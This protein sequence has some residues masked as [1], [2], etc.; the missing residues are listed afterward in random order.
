[1]A[2]YHREF[3]KHCIGGWIN[4]LHKHGRQLK[5]FAKQSIAPVLGSE[6][7]LVS[8]K[9]SVYKGLKVQKL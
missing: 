2:L 6:N 5:V 3:E 8:L 1:M 9:Y 7:G 4:F